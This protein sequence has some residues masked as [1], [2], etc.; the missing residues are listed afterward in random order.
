MSVTRIQDTTASSVTRMSG[1][2]IWRTWSGSLGIGCNRLCAGCL[3]LFTRRE[4]AGRVED[5]C[6]LRD[7]VDQRRQKGVEKARRCQ[8]NADGIDNQR[9]VEIL[10]DDAPAVAR[11]A[12]SIYKLC[13]IIADQND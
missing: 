7:D 1:K 12:D 8:A 11:D 2:V 13:Q 6:K 4:Q 3:I 5:E 10:Q 9:A